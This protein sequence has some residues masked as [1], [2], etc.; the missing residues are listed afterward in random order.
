[1]ADLPLP[2]D[3]AQVTPA[4]GFVYYPNFLEVDRAGRLLDLFWSELGWQHQ[5]IRLYGQLVKQPRLSCWYA[6]EGTQYSYS[7]LNLTSL[8]WHPAL[9]NLKYEL[10]NKLNT[11]FNSVLANAYRDGGDSMGWHS[12]D[13]T[14]LG[15]IPCIASVS[16]G[17][18]RRFLIRSNRSGPSQRMNLDHGS[19]LVMQGDSQR[20]YKHA[21]PKSRRLM[22]LRINLTFRM[23]YNKIS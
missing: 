9:S 1:M 19:L 14:E 12:D 7:G 6:D 18:C 10:E 23:V 4:R 16:L 21:L 8:P 3:S 5:T 20:D 13:E 11:C 2:L 15:K 22:D 17:E